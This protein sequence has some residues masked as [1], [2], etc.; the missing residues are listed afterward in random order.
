MIKNLEIE[1][2]KSIK[3]LKLDCKR[4]N[5]FI[6]EPNTGKSNIL[7]T[8]GVLSFNSY[9]DIR[10]F[11]RFERMSN[12]FYDEN[13]DEGIEI[14]ADDTI[15]EI[16]FESG[17]FK[18]R[19]YDGEGESFS[20]NFNYDGGGSR[21]RPKDLSPIKFY[22][23]A[24]KKGFPRKESDFLLPPSGDN[25]LAILMTHKNLKGTASRIFEHFG[26]RLVLRPQ[27][28]KIEILKLQEDV[29]ISYPY[30][31]ASETLQRIIFYTTAIDSNKDSVL[32]FEEPESHSFPYYTKFL[33]ERI[34]LDKNKNQYFIST[35]NPYFLLSILEKAHRDEVAIFITYFEDYQTK[36]KPLDK[37]ELEEIM[38]LGIDVFFNIERFLEVKE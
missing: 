35:H 10:D 7:E 2:F 5:L 4:I 17:D 34:A 14:R 26:F 20:F 22:R 29:L 15:L 3:H 6:G 28:N 36:V 38:D 12:L 11:I 16:G 32:V 24:V 23:F 33:A 30:S 9:G 19:C 25:L 18:G 1:N 31:L 21:S 27:E 8:L 37:K 13:L